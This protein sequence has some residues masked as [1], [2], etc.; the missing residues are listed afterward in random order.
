MCCVPCRRRKVYLPSREGMLRSAERIGLKVE[1][2][3]ILGTS[4]SGPNLVIQAQGLTPGEDSRRVRVVRRRHQVQCVKR[5]CRV[6]RLPP[7]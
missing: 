7:L 3:G 2:W 5:A 4:E 1:R 6:A